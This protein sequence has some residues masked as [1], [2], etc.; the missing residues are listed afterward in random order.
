[1]FTA[2]KFDAETWADLFEEAG[3]RFAGPVA[4]HHDGYAMWASDLTPWNVKD[5]GPKRDI[6]LLNA[7][8]GLQVGGAAGDLAEG[9]TLATASIDSGRALKVLDK[10]AEF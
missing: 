1:M 5:T 10:L 3:A 8:A 6:V 9:I 4:E 2:D 7:A